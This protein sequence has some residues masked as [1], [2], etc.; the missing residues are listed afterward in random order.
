[1]GRRTSISVE[2]DAHWAERRRLS[3]LGDR[4]FHIRQWEARRLRETGEF[5]ERFREGMGAA[6]FK[7]HGLTPL[8]LRLARGFI[9]ALRRDNMPRVGDWECNAAFLFRA[10]AAGVR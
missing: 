6:S 4:Q 1:M 2:I 10:R 7:D 8:T 9:R 5:A 3:R